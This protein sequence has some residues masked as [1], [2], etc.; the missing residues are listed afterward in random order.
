MR[1]IDLLPGGRTDLAALRVKDRTAAAEIVA[2]LEEA[3]ADPRIFEKL[4]THGDVTI[5]KGH[6]V[7]VVGWV[8]ARRGSNNLF[9]L[10]ALDPPVPGYRVLY[11]FDWHTRRIGILAVVRRGDDTYE[12]DGNLARR[13][14]EDWRIATGGVPT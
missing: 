2:L 6:L 9:R 10:K 4:T 12:L 8:A 1:N 7:N 3:D 13:I 11:G 5:G 14:L